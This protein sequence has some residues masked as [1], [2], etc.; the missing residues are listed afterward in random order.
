M[1]ELPDVTVYV[2]RLRALIVGSTLTGVRL[3]SPFLLRSVD[4]PI[5]SASGRR[6]TE[7]R[8]LGKRIVVGLAGIAA[9]DDP[10]SEASTIAV[11]S[12]RS[13]VATPSSRPA[14]PPRTAP[15]SERSRPRIFS[16]ESA[17]PIRT[18]SCTPQACPR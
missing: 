13:N 18:K 10:G 11:V 17:T 14:S 9:A 5:G 3:R 7:V 12:S 16:A 15:G 6:V 4:P 1:P 8:R 2:E